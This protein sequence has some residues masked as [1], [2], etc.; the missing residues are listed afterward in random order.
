MI[1]AIFD[2]PVEAGRVVDKLLANGVRQDHVTVLMGD[3][4]HRRLREQHEAL[5]DAADPAAGEPARAATT[6]ALLGGSLAAVA[7]VA[8]SFTGVGLIAIGPIA[9]LLGGGA[10][11]AAAG[12][13]LGTL[14]GRGIRG[15]IA[16]IYERDL[17]EGSVLV[18]VSVAPADTER[19]ESILAEG[20][21]RDFARLDRYT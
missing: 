3:D 9:A 8:L 4:V 18:G 10:V 13:L 17:Q 7:G 19:I 20:G 5:H 6:G 16:R 15:D 12:G 2:G 11:G 21:G 1:T 14:M